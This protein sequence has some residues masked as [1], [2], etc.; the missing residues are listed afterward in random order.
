[1]VVVISIK[2][3]WFWEKFI[4]SSIIKLIMKQIISEII[5]SI[6]SA[7]NSYQNDRNI[8][9]SDSRY[10]AYPITK[11]SFHEIKNN[12]AKKR[13]AFVDGGN[14]EL[15]K[16]QNLSLSAIRIACSVFEDNKKIDSRQFDFYALTKSFVDKEITYET[17]IFDLNSKEI[18]PD[19]NDLL[20]SADDGTIKN[21][22]YKAN[23]SKI[24]DV[25]RRFAELN[26]ACYIIENRLADIIVLDGTLQS[27]VTNEAKYFEKMYEKARKNSIII[28]SVAKTT[29]LVTNTGNS[30]FIFLNSLA[31][32]GKWYCS[33]VVEI[34]HKDHKAE[35]FF[36]KLNE[37]AK[38]IFRIE[39]YKEVPFK[40]EE[41]MGLLAFNST[42][43]VF[44]GYP[45]GLIDADNF[46]RITNEEKEM[47]R[48]RII[49]G[50][51][52]ADLLNEFNAHE[53]LDKIK[54]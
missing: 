42:D 6:D 29:N 54:F 20:L 18:L 9:F 3:L 24:G 40:I 37:D 31:P 33:P 25:A 13:I 19:E 12:E 30:A 35:M 21:W 22:I 45:Y 14:A 53:I 8:F 2:K 17:K 23:I 16:S 51:D 49:A 50:L 48:I 26:A 10:Q 32:K 39:F 4:K 36:A 46:A 47:L 7:K 11:E 1:M 44:P 41:S 38:H 15:I 27:S 43:S 28:C 52:N 34:N 5:K